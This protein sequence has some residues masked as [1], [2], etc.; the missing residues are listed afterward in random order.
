ME[1]KPQKK[2]GGLKKGPE[3]CIRHYLNLPKRRTLPFENG[4]PTT[5]RGLPKNYGG[6]G[7]IIRAEK[8]Q[9]SIPASKNPVQAVFGGG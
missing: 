7:P 6:G 8:G 3:V 4:K 1:E 5:N 2:A 9:K